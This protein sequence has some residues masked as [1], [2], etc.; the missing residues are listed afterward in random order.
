MRILLTQ[1]D[2]I[3][4]ITKVKL[5]KR[6]KMAHLYEDKKTVLSAKLGQLLW[7]SKQSCPDIAFEVTD[8]AERNNTTIVE[9]LKRLNKIIKRLKSDHVSLKFH[10]FGKNLEIHVFT[11]ALFGNFYESG[12]QGGHFIIFT[13]PFHSGRI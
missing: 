11:D 1:K 12:S 13:Q 6:E 2:Y 7:I 8:L 5:D 9:D 4:N 3:N 10:S